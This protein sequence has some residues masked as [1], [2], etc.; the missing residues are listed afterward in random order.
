MSETLSAAQV[1]EQL[2]GAM[3][4][5][6]GELFSLLA[7]ELTWLFWRWDQFVVLYATKPSRLEI[8]NRSASLFFWIVQDTLWYDTLLAISRLAGPAATGAKQNLSV[9]RLPSLLK[10]D[11]LRN[12]V[13]ALLEEVTEKAAFAIDW[14]NR[15]IAHRDLDLALKKTAKPLP[16][17]TRQSVD[18][19]LDAMAAV[20]NAVSRHYL[21]STTAYRF[22]PGPFGAETLLHVASPT[23]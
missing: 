20:L 10:D 7:D 19:V 9:Q 4:R 16:D 6:L 12:T 14:R 18:E 21:D 8:L 23:A 15:H 1:R 22:S 3:G 17:A 5:D 13:S 11:R 2:I